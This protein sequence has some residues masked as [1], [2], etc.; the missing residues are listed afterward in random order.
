MDSDDE[1]QEAGVMQVESQNES[2]QACTS[3]IPWKMFL[4]FDDFLFIDEF[5][6]TVALN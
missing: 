1:E 2:N 4:V 3:H 5:M 6:L